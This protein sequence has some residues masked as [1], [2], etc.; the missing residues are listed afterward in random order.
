MNVMNLQV[1]A[2]EVRMFSV[3]VKAIGYVAPHFKFMNLYC[4]LSRML[5]LAAAIW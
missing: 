2:P 1:F 3:K 4:G 5:V